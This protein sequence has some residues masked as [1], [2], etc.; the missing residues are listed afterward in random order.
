M[1]TIKPSLHFRKLGF[2]FGRF[3]FVLYPLAAS[4]LISSVFFGPVSVPS[5]ES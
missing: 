3:Y 2:S 5:L 4:V 1:T